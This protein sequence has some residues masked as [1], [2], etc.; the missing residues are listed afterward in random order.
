[1]NTRKAPATTKNR[2]I[3]HSIIIRYLCKIECHLRQC[4]ASGSHLRRRHRRWLLISSNYYLK[5]NRFLTLL[6][7]SI[8]MARVHRLA[9]FY[10]T[11]NTPDHSEIQRERERE[12]HTQSLKSDYRS[13]IWKCNQSQLSFENTLSIRW[14]PRQRTRRNGCGSHT[15]WHTQLKQQMNN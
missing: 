14:R 2:H 5:K 15:E 10:R 1:M 4:A 6:H 8:Q 12:K 11:Q 7:L 3:D 13:P 9:S